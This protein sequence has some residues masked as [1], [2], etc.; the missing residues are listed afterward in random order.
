LRTLPFFATMP[1]MF[2]TCINATLGRLRGV[3]FASTVAALAG[4][5][6]VQP[7][8][9]ADRIRVGNPSV[10]SFSFLPLRLGIAQGIFAK[11][12]VDP[13]E[14]TLNGSAKLH[15]AMTAGSLDM[16]IG[17]GTDLIFLLKGVPEIAVAAMAGPPLLLSVIV[18]YDSPARTADDL[19][20]KRIGISTVN[21]LTQWLMRELARQKGW[22]PDSMTYVTVGAEL[23]NQVAA[24]TT[25][26]IDAVVSST[27]LGLQ[28]AE[29]KRGRLLFPASDIVKD[30]MIHTIY[31]SDQ[32]A[33]ERPDTV[34]RFLQG[35]FETIEF[36]RKNKDETVRASRARTNFSTAVEEQQY[37]L[38]M[39]MFSG[40][41]RFDSRALGAIQRSFVDLQL[42]DQEPDLTK[43]CTERFL[44]PR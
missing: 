7:A 38:V 44:P 2:E 16:G 37:D 4:V 36:M 11:Y 25:G 20:G 14:V 10:Q 8:L 17:S 41:G 43:Y 34:R 5:V 27:A 3:A 31:A 28:L 40:S 1:R 24:L 42:I 29:A 19:K 6:P 35:W 13:E 30:F 26:Q 23:P 21:S 39:P 15:Q 32:M 18:P 33:R 12:G 22:G 9:A